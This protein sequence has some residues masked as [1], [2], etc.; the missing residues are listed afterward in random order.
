MASTHTSVKMSSM[1]A[2]AFTAL[3]GNL[4]KKFS[5]QRSCHCQKSSC[6][7]IHVRARKFL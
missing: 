4:F 1:N 5:D 2:P 6:H 7:L 3:K